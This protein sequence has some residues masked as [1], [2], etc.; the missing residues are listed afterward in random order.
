MWADVLKKSLPLFCVNFTMCDGNRTENTQ[1]LIH[2]HSN[3]KFYVII[4]RQMIDD[5]LLQIAFLAMNFKC[6]HFCLRI[7]SCLNMCS[8]SIFLSFPCFSFKHKPG[9]SQ[10][11]SHL[12]WMYMYEVGAEWV[13]ASSAHHLAVCLRVT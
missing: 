3:N 13:G 11:A 7:F 12:H 6:E 2:Y 9:T 4:C 1:H 5:K 10:T 8:N